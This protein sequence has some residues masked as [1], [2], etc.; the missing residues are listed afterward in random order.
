MKLKEIDCNVFS[1]FDGHGGITA[2]NYLQKNFNQILCDNLEKTN[3]IISAIE[4]T[5]NDIDS[6]LLSNMD[7]FSGSCAT[8]LM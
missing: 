6:T 1:V 5:F 4:K 7:D 2:C 8:T 3:N